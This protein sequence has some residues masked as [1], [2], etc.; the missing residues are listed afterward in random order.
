MKPNIGNEVQKFASEVERTCFWI[1]RNTNEVHGL[2]IESQPN[3]SGVLRARP[4]TISK[5]HTAEVLGT[6][7]IR[8]TDVIKPGK[9]GIAFTLGSGEAFE[10]YS[11]QT[12]N[13]RYGNVE[14]PKDAPAETVGTSTATA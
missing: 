3:K 14:M 9:E 8:I 11:P 1:D 2:V 5:P 7:L 10:Y 13:T 12:F 6:G 4:S